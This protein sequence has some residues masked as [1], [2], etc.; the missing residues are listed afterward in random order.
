[1]DSWHLRAVLLPDSDAVQDRWVA[2]GGWSDV[3]TP[4]AE[5][6]PGRFALPGLID[7]HSHVSLA[8][9]AEGPVPRD[10][11]GAQAARES[12][13][14][15]GVAVLRDAGGDPAVVL[16]MKDC[17]GSPQLVA[18]GRHL[19]PPGMYFPA[20]H[21]PVEPENLIDT[22]LAE[23]RAG[24]TWT[25]LV[26]D[27]APPAEAGK[28]RPA[29][30]PTFDLELVGRLIAAVHANGGRVAA[31]VTTGVVADL[32]RLGL[33]SVEHGTALDKTALSEMARRGTAWTPTLCAVLSIDPDDADERRRVVSE[34]REVFRA[35]LPKAVAWGVPVLTGSDVVGS[36]PREVAL[37]VE[38]GLTP[39]DALRAA[40]TT[41]VAFLR[42]PRKGRAPS[43]V[44][45][46]A[47]PREAPDVLEHP[48]A[49]IIEGVRV[50]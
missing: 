4:G 29:A 34:R 33:D 21:Q 43:V 2:G 17:R 3:P 6:L 12:W 38:H 8:E 42:P 18:S 16:A 25:K 9:G 45:Y 24:A 19:A 49:V 10:L 48:A 40:T 46:E 47:D 27:F 23:L 20:I 44:T 35:L 22:A 26:A 1:M 36:I 37:L 14:R 32:V 15:E 11:D 50:G 41:A 7:A 28:P 13:A 5:E 39:L 30:E 31:H